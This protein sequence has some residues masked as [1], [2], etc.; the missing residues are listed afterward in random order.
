MVEG[1]REG[2][3]KGLGV[4]LTKTSDTYV[5]FSNNLKIK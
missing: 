4:E 1:D 2:T 5:K 3:G